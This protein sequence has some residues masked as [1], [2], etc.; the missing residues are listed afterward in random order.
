M[1]MAIAMVRISLFGMV[2]I[3]TWVTY[4]SEDI[5]SDNWYRKIH[6]TTVTFD[7]HFT[8]AMFDIHF[9]T[10]TFDIDIATVTF[11]ITIATPTLFI[12]FTTAVSEH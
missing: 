1:I 8:T 10:A 2:S 3:Q 9:T 5:V 4:R 11:D 7:V 12:N 6:I